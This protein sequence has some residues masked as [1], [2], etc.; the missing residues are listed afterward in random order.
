MAHHANGLGTVP[1]GE[2]VG[3]EAAVDEGHVADEVVIEKVLE[4]RK[5]LGRGQL[6]L[7]G[8]GLGGHRADVERIA[9]C[10]VLLGLRG[11]DLLKAVPEAKSGEQR[12]ERE[13]QARE[14][15]I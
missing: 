12:R 2:G 5:D 8:H 3:A 7:V 11:G 14:R 9:E 10:V 4:I 13:K 6:S 1:R 15:T